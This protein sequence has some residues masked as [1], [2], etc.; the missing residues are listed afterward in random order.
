[1]DAGLS[2]G[3]RREVLQDGK[4]RLG[5]KALRILFPWTMGQSCIASRLVLPLF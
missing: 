4:V 2:A 3:E 5:T 1:M